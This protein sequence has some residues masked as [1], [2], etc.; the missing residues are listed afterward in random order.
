[1]F[2]PRRL[3]PI[4][5]QAA[6]SSKFWGGAEDESETESEEVSDSDSDSDSSS[7]SESQKKGPSKCVAPQAASPSRRR[8]E[9]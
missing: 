5:A 1:M 7:S 6:S 3:T 2:V 8:L 9:G 4:A